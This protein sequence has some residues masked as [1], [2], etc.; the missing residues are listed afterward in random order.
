MAAIPGGPRTVDLAHGSLTLTADTQ[1]ENFTLG[2]SVW[3]SPDGFDL[4][5]GRI[6]AEAPLPSWNPPPAASSETTPDPTR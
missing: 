4:S 6:G 5:V 3:F 2:N 1:V